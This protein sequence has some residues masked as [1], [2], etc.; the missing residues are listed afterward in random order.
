MSKGCGK[1]D[2]SGVAEIRSDG[3]YPVKLNKIINLFESLPE[4]ERRETLVSA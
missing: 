4:D 2:E 3:P 1:L